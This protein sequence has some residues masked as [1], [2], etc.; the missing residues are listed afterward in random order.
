MVKDLFIVDSHEDIAW[1]ASFG[2]DFCEPVA[3]WRKRVNDGERFG[4]RLVSLPDLL[5]SRVRLV[6]GTIFTL[7]ARAASRWE[8]PY[9]SNADEAHSQG[10][11]QVD[12]YRRVAEVHE[13]INLITNRRELNQ[14]L[15]EVETGANKLG[16]IMSI[17][18]ADPIRDPSELAEWVNKGVRL[19]GPAWKSTRYCGGTG[20]HGPLTKMG[21]A[22][23]SE[24]EKQGVILDI[25]HMAEEAFYNSLEAFGGQVIASH[26]NCRHYIRTDRQLTDEMLRLLISRNAVIGLV[27]FDRFLVSHEEGRKSNIE[28]A[29]RHISHICE[30]TGNSRSVGLGTDWDGGFGGEAIPEPMTGLNDLYMLGEAMLRHGFNEQDVRNLF[31]ENWIRVLR[32]SLTRFD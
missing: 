15:S 10:M 21:Y 32:Q 8:K 16:L 17:E 12:F 13:T 4:E 26:S 7:P 28:D 14:H 3:S 30:L 20:E 25:S 11:W 27:L 19:V 22:L 9:Y 18:G 23:L 31:H 1:N 5:E 6:I 2:R 29:I 24:M